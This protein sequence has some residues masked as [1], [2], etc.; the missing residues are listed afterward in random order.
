M[1]ELVE[2]SEGALWVGDLELDRDGPVEGY[3]HIH[4]SWSW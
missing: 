4:I 1:D 2:V 3:E